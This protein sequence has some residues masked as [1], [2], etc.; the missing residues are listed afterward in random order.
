MPGAVVSVHRPSLIP[1]LVSLPLLRDY[2]SDGDCRVTDALW[3][4]PD[5]LPLYPPSRG[6]PNPDSSF[7]NSDSTPYRRHRSPLVHGFPCIDRRCRFIRGLISCVSKTSGQLCVDRRKRRVLCLPVSVTLDLSP[8]VRVLSSTLL[9][10]FFGPESSVLPV[11]LPPSA[12]SPFRG[13][14][15]GVSLMTFC[16]NLPMPSQE[17]FPG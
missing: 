1:S 17:G 13:L 4:D 6:L 10:G 14:L 8:V 9:P 12:P 15:L 7:H 5:T 16:G 2:S 11:N 3:L